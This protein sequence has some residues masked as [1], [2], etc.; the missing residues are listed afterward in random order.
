MFSKA[1][2]IGCALGAVLTVCAANAFGQP[3][4]SCEAPEKP[5]K[6]ENQE[7]LDGFMDEARGYMDC[8]KAFFEEQAEASKLAAEA[9]NATRKEMEEY[10]ASVNQ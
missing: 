2:R 1:T 6:F 7:E 8:L 9:A 5:E 4:H 3:E 10:A